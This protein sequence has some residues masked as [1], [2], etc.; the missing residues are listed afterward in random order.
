M[1]GQIQRGKSGGGRRGYYLGITTQ[2][3]GHKDGLQVSVAK[4]LEDLNSRKLLKPTKV[5]VNYVGESTSPI[6]FILCAHKDDCIFGGPNC[7]CQHNEYFHETPMWP[8]TLCLDQ[9]IM[10]ILHIYPLDL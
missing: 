4:P 1:P 10:D 2:G 6:S 7:P 5:K 9:V 3:E 8:P